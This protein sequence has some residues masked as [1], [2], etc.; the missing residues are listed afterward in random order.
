MVLLHVKSL[1][2]RAVKR[3]QTQ[4]LKSREFQAV[5]LRHPDETVAHKR[6]DSRCLGRFVVGGCRC[7]G[8][9]SS[10]RSA[11]I[12]SVQHPCDTMC[13]QTF[14]FAKAKFSK[15]AAKVLLWDLRSKSDFFLRRSRCFCTAG[16]TLKKRYRSLAVILVIVMTILAINIIR[17]S[18]LMFTK[19]G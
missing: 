1:E 7:N 6:S 14:S 3:S 10:P 19:I 2:T 17:L 18:V 8:A 5:V 9:R 13:R 16:S 12:T 11:I 4:T 15:L